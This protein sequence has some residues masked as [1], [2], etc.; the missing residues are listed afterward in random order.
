[1]TFALC[2]G[3]CATSII[4]HVFSF[5][6]FEM[7]ET[8]VIKYVYEEKKH[9]LSIIGFASLDVLFIGPFSVTSCLNVRPQCNMTQKMRILILR[10]LEHVGMHGQ[11]IISRVMINRVNFSKTDLIERNFSTK[12]SFAVN[13][14]SSML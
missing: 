2:H 10:Y 8:C 9:D 5:F 1:M 13:P 11:I 4:V 7:D 3:H 14:G 12:R 6:S